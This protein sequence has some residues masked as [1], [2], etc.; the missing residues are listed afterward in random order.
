[1][2]QP[3][4]AAAKEK[5]DRSISNQQNLRARIARSASELRGDVE[6][7]PEITPTVSQEPVNIG[8]G[9]DVRDRT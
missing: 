1:M 8:V 5:L 3:N 2:T 6:E 4:I 9:A 7:S